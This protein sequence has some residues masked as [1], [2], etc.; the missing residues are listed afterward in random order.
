[1]RIFFKNGGPAQIGQS[2]FAKSTAHSVKRKPL[3]NLAFATIGTVI[4]DKLLPLALF[5]NFHFAPIHI[6]LL[7]FLIFICKFALAP[8]KLSKISQVEIDLYGDEVLRAK[9]VSSLV[10]QSSMM[11]V[12]HLPIGHHLRP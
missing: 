3:V 2:A 12:A 6:I 9:W 4:L 5:E 8:Q 10:V 11:A 1:M 7:L